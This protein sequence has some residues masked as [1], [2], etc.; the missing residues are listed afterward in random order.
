MISYIQ[1]LQYYLWCVILRYYSWD[2]LVE[3]LIQTQNQHDFVS[4]SPG[5]TVVQTWTTVSHLK[6]SSP[7]VWSRRLWLSSWNKQQLQSVTYSVDRHG[8]QTWRT[9][10]SQL[11]QLLL[12][13]THSLPCSESY[14]EPAGRFV[15][16]L[17]LIR[18]LRELGTKREK[19]NPDFL[20][21]KEKR[22]LLPLL[23]FSC[24]KVWPCGNV[25]SSWRGCC[26]AAALLGFGTVHTRW[27]IETPPAA[28]F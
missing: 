16:W 21:K 18:P 12:S 8:G 14:C 1:I 23:C 15:Q 2:A 11:P 27:G 26:W 22:N 6:R 3:I 13:T 20:K 5:P 28:G 4:E 10:G 25:W 24:V 9:E 17:L 19:I 7:N